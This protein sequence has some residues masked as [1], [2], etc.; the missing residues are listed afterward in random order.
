MTL[1]KSLEDLQ[2]LYGLPQEAAMIKEIDHLNHGYRKIIETAKFCTLSTA[3]PEGL[4][5]S[6]RGDAGPVVRVQDERTLLMPD[7]RGNNRIDSL[8]NIIRD[9][10]VSLM[11]MITGWTNVLRINGTAVI[12]AEDD[13][14][15]SFA[16]DNQKPRSVIIITIQSVYFQ[17]ARAIM[18]ADLWDADDQSGLNDLPTP[19]GIMKEIKDGFDAAAYDREWPERAAKTMW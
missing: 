7:R 15:N 6:P 17:C 16:I 2:A 18:R 5:C 3:G 10:R 13:L 9:P 8:R 4:D 19:G 11:F 14:L 1:I 12:S